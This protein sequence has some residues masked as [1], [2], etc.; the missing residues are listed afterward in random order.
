MVAVATQFKRIFLR[1]LYWSAEESGN[2]LLNVL[3]AA[4]KGQIKQVGAG[5]VL[6]GSAGNGHSGSW[7]IP[8]DFNTTDATTMLGELVDRYYEAQT[9]LTAEQDISSP[10]DLQIFNEMMDKLRP[11]TTLRHDYT[12]LRCEQSEE[13]D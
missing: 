3:K 1:N 11:V 6:V 13:T 10:T 9:E 8:D 7:E 2:S 5:K 4:V 12:G